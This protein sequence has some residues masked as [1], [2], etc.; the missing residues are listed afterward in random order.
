MGIRKTSLRS[1]IKLNYEQ[2]LQDSHQIHLVIQLKRVKLIPKWSKN[3]HL[4]N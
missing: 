2:Q 4:V 3:S 1:K